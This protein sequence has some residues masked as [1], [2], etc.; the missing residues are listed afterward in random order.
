MYKNNVAGVV[1]I[2]LWSFCA[3]HGCGG[4]IKNLPTPLIYATTPTLALTHCVS[5]KFLS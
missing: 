2:P 5:L 4:D 1:K 3:T